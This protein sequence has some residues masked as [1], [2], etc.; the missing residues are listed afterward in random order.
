[1]EPVWIAHLRTVLYGVSECWHCCVFSMRRVQLAVTFCAKVHI[2]VAASRS[3][4]DLMTA[5]AQ[6]G[7]AVFDNGT[8]SVL[9]TGY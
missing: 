3:R 8:L 1:V 2:A 6:L 5:G 9:S 4:L 7:A